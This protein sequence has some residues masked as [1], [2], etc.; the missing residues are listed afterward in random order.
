M[1]AGH[2]RTAIGTFGD[3][4]ITAVGTRYRALTRYRDLDGRL[5]K[6]TATAGSE[7]AVRARLKER[8]VDRAGYG[9][10]G[11]LS[12]A[13]PFGDLCDLWLAD[14]AMR[15]ISEG[16]KDNYRDDL[17]LHV[18]PAFE[19]Y[20]LGEITTGRVEWFLKSQS[21]ISWSRAKHTRTL[22]NQMFAFALRHDGIARNPVEGTSA[23]NRPKH[24]VH[25]A[26]RHDGGRLVER[27]AMFAASHQP[28]TAVR[29]GCTV[30]GHPLPSRQSDHQKVDP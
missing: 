24:T 27:A 23:L 5:R 25:K 7:R 12:V 19:A 8:L 4:N 26:M 18:G 22:L 16:T 11:L 14:L 29:D 17:R 6:V 15:E 20:T 28:P 3:I 1:T 2:P 30:L 21:A 10:G 9:R 13:S